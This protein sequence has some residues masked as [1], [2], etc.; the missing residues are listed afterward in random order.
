MAVRVTSSFKTWRR[1]RKMATSNPSRPGRGR[2]ARPADV[3]KITEGEDSAAPVLLVGL[4]RWRERHTGGRQR[5]V[6]P[7]PPVRSPRRIVSIHP[8]LCQATQ[9]T[10][11]RIQGTRT[12]KGA[13][14]PIP[15][16]P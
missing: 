15:R 12:P 3:P 6:T 4:M 2:T 7:G 5:A 13:P 9:R 1:G 10:Q 8:C 16:H 11:M 14:I